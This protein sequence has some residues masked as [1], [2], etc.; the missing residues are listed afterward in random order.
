MSGSFLE[1]RG[2]GTP[3][4]GPLNSPPRW[5]CK[6][7]EGEA[8]SHITPR[9]QTASLLHPSSSETPCGISLGE[10]AMPLVVVRFPLKSFQV[11]RGI[12]VE[13]EGGVGEGEKCITGD[14]RG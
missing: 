2:A 9:G 4:S 7:K 6:K 12:E 11:S 13:G 1:A 14:E 10:D 5:K 3:E 8:C